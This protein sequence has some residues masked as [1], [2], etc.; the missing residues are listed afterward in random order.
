MNQR[1]ASIFCIML[2]FAISAVQASQFVKITLPADEVI[3][4]KL[5]KLHNDTLYLYAL[6]DQNQK[7]QIPITEIVSLINLQEPTPLKYFFPKL[8]QDQKIAII[9][10]L[11]HPD[12]V[13]E[14][15]K[16]SAIQGIYAERQF[17]ITILFGI[18]IILVTAI[19]LILRF[20]RKADIQEGIPGVEE[21]AKT[22]FFWADY[23]RRKN[24]ED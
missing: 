15:D 22:T 13:K 20:R 16:Q 14:L 1:H 4:A 5:E 7:R 24:G 8:N 10:A 18:F 6:N 17:Q 11:I 3:V 21:M 9:N 2:I 19:T 12:Q 23:H